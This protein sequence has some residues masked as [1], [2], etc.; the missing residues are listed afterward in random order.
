M[1]NFDNILA[2]SQNKYSKNIIRFKKL[3]QQN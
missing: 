3:K 1:Y 2:R